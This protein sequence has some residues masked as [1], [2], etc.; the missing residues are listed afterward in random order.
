MVRAKFECTHNNA[1]S[2][3]QLPFPSYVVVFSP[4]TGGSE[5]NDKFY[6]STP[7]GDLTFGN[8]SKEVSEQFSIGQEYYI[9]VIDALIP[10]VTRES[11]KA[12]LLFELRKPTT[13]EGM[14]RGNF[15]ITIVNQNMHHPERIS[16]QGMDNLYKAD[17]ID[18]NYDDNLVNKN[19]KFIQI[20]GWDN[21]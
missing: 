8:V 17:F 9:D 6:N 3:P 10:K 15:T 7:Y 18:E 20:V 5:E 16:W 11:K 12:A 1:V 13:S 21:Y 2:D 4:V 14:C 19:A